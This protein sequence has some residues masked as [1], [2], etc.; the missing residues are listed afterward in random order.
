M[1]TPTF[2][3]LAFALSNSV[4]CPACYTP[5]AMEAPFLDKFSLLLDELKEGSH[6]AVITMTG[7]CCPV[8]TA[9]RMAFEC[10]RQLL[11]GEGRASLE[12]FAEVLGLLSLNGDHH[13][14]GKLRMKGLPFV[15]Y[16]ERAQLVTM[17]TSEVPWL[18]FN[19][20]REHIAVNWLQQKWPKLK[21]IK[22]AL[23][24]ADDVIKYQKW[25]SCSEEH[26]FI[27]MGRPG[28]T[29]KVIEGARRHGVRMNTGHFIVGPELPDISSTAVREALQKE[30]A[31]ALE[32][33]L[34]PN[35]A[36]WLVRSGIYSG[37]G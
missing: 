6:V 34:H 30:D 13:V 9:H 23:N 8:T 27:T 18:D 19:P 17:A 15:S 16:V 11:V 4:A 3:W 37:R 2:I 10:S 1:L 5:K 7:S 14:A 24:G 21:F 28:Y 32:S 12:H 35:V 31:Q 20:T 36:A 33:L 22:Y 26:R 29:E 25:R